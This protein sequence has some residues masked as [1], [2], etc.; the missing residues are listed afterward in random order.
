MYLTEF[1]ISGLAGSEKV[2]SQ[3]LNKD[4]NVFFGLNGSGKTSLLKILHSAMTNDV[5]ILKNVP[6][7]SAEVKLYSIDSNQVF[8]R[9]IKQVDESN[10]QGDAFKDIFLDDILDDI[11]LDELPENA[12]KK[13]FENVRSNDL[14]WKTEPKTPKFKGL[15]H[16]YLPTSRLY[17][18]GKSWRSLKQLSEEQLDLFFARSLQELWTHYSANTLRVIRKAQ[19]EGIANILKAMLS[20]KKPNKKVAP[21]IDP[22]TAYKRVTAFLKRQEGAIAN[23]LG[24]PKAFEKRYLAEPHIQ[25]VISDINEIEQE[26]EQAMKPRQKLEQ[27]IQ[28]LLSGNKEVQ[29]KDRTIDVKTHDG[30]NIGLHS[31]S[32]GE[33]Q[34]ILILLETFLAGESSILIDEPEISMHIDWQQ[35]LIS[36]MT[37]LNSS[38]QI[39]L[40]T[41][42]PEIMADVDDNR[43]FRL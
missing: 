24:E 23:I 26:I 41:H 43:I 20:T 33:K 39:I 15:R 8:R 9:A 12:V 40:A 25:S 3:K 11:P 7:K 29:F 35:Q 10:R 1:S 6:F 18:G 28:N 32:S 38:A 42:S 22:K 34:L 30:T 4:V 19:E 21:K 17:L 16:K 5:D 13:F 14:A 37:Q 31:L 36:A 2:Y 27:L